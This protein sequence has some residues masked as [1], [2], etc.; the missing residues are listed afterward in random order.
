MVFRNY[1]LFFVLIFFFENSFSQG[2]RARHFIPGALHHATKNI[3]E[4]SPGNYIATG[5]T[6]ESVNNVNENYYLIMGL[7]SVGG[8][9]WKKKYGNNDF[10]YYFNDF[11]NRALYKHDNHIYYAGCVRENN[12]QI[13]VLLKIDFNG[14]TVWQK[15]YR[16]G[17]SSEDIIPQKVTAS[18][19]GGFLIT[20]FYETW[21]NE[22]RPALILKTDKDGNELWRK[23][24]N[25]SGHNVQD[26]K[27]IIQDSASKKIVIAGF[28]Y[29]GMTSP[30]T[31]YDN[32]VILDS[33][34]NTLSRHNFCGNIG[35]SILD[36]IQLKDGG[37]VAVG[38]N[39]IN[40]T[41]EIN[42][43]LYYTH[44]YIFKLDI[45]NPEQPIW[46]IDNFDNATKI[47]FFTCVYELTNGDIMAGGIFD[48]LAIYL[49]SIYGYDTYNCMLRTARFSTNGELL[50]TRYYKYN[51]PAQVPLKF[52]IILN[53]LN[54]TSDGGMIASLH[55]QPNYFFVKFDSNGCDTTLSYCANPT[56]IR[57]EA[58]NSRR[59]SVFPNPASKTLTIERAFWPPAE[60][61]QIQI[62]DI[63]GRRKIEIELLSNKKEIN[64]ESLEDGVYFV[65]VIQNGNVVY[66]SK[67]VK[68][69]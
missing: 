2:W 22:G 57:K 21:T 54:A 42:G 11:T 29:V 69:N 33:L 8:V 4:T 19:D 46:I 64:V 63:L 41:L 13:G 9:K 15:M 37:I 26:G 67:F 18:V 17:N 68:Q 65:R 5:V 1:I 27:A 28:Q 58:F 6:V 7:D 31:M 53:S 50:Q 23:K 14:D 60:N 59:Y 45:N 47:N 43:D 20:G 55:R 66:S 30:Y 56:G 39:A 49:D 34:G 12:R 40:K 3:I 44:S 62:T 48:T 10:L 38:Y 16:G 51:D 25:K 36:M 24:I 61:C 32:I 35:A 52:S